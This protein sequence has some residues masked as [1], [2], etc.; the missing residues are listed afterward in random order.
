MEMD[1]YS[2]VREERRALLEQRRVVVVRQLRRLVFELTD[3][4]RQ[5]DQIKRS[6]RC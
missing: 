4:D 1:A 5:L 3:L 6:D 2:M